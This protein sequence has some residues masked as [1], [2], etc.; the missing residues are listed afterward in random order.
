MSRRRTVL[1]G[2]RL[3]VLLAA[4]LLAAEAALRLAR[5]G[6]S[7]AAFGRWQPR[8]RW[9][10][11]RTLEERGPWPRPGGRARW[12]LQAGSPEIDYRLD[13]HGFRVAADV[14]RRGG[15]RVLAIGDSNVFGY[16]VSAEESF[17]AILETLLLARGV[18]V[19]VRNAGVCASDVAQQERWLETAVERAAPQVVILAVSPW[20]LR[21][22]R[23]QGR[24][25]LALVEK[26]AHALV[27]TT[28]SPAAWSA[29]VD[30]TRRRLLHGLGAFTGWLPTSDAA[31][32]LAPLLEPRSEFDRRFA[33]AADH[34]GR[35]V[36]RS[37]ARNL[38]PLL[39]LVPLDVQTTT[40]RNRL[41]A[42][43]RL[44]YPSWG[45][46]DR[47]YTRDPRYADGMARR[48]KALAVPLIDV[49]ERLVT[50]A[51]GSYL[52]DDYHLSEA[53]HRRI[54]EEI[55]A[56][57]RDA[58]LAGAVATGSQRAIP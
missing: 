16:G 48:A 49:T 28:A 4:A 19:E 41:Y 54:A 24:T 37:R 8:A 17:P 31:W 46:V 22:D 21:T 10:E 7:R 34:V 3:L 50:H 42:A 53:G 26:L 13:D 51:S 35:M 15:C 1:R 45:F 38:T 12:A 32:H 39:V 55:A 40:S 23:P 43:E 9:S 58:C 25:D 20:S 27:R 44:P 47:D 18:D 2:V 6:P 11:I 30:R 52:Q 14:P 29:V 57:V 5:L 56:P 33:E 36:E